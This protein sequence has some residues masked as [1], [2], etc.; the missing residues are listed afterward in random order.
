MKPLSVS[1]KLILGILAGALL[2]W[3]LYSSIEF[4]DDKVQTSWSLRAFKNPYLAAQHFIQQSGLEVVD[5]DSLVKLDTLDEISTLLITDAN[6]VVSQR[7]L[8]QVLEWLEKGGNIILTA[9]SVS[10][11]EDLLLQKFGVEVEWSQTDD[12]EEIERQSISEQFREYNRQIEEG[13]TKQ[14]ISESFTSE[15]VVT[16]IEF[17]ED[18]GDLEVAF[19]HS[20]VLFHPYIDGYDEDETE[21]PDWIEPNSWSSSD[22]GVHLI[23]FDVGSGL[24][25][26]VSDSSIWT[27]YRIDEYDHA[28][29][30]WV[31]SSKYGGFAILRPVLKDSL[32]LLALQH[33]SELL[34]AL[35]AMIA[36]WLWHSAQRFGR[37]TVQD[38]STSRAMAE[39]FSS[40]SSYLWQRNDGVYLITP[41]RQ[42]VL[43]RA[44]LA[45]GEFG[46]ADRARQ[47]ELIGKR[48]DL[49]PLSIEN[50]MLEDKFNEASFVHYVKLLKHI[51]RSL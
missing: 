45:I 39:Y 7:Q 10:N 19:D 9:D 32:W 6:Q 1:A 24:L 50:A 17:G 35:T 40:I 26:I 38:T 51:E 46:Q 47:M 28:Y 8:D 14:E 31:L 48:C 44:S 16:V 3:A 33:A 41:L 49:S 22:R 37:I 29:L 25:T 36:F 18:I 2:V 15:S 5:A 30:L 11:S 13:K 4:Y 34:I 12:G 27:S 20:K 21:D 43:R 42:R 23:Q